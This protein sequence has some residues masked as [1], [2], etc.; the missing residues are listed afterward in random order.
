LEAGKIVTITPFPWDKNCFM[1]KELFFT[2][3]DSSNSPVYSDYGR[4]CADIPEKIGY[5]VNQSGT[6]YLKI[7]SKRNAPPTKYGLTIHQQTIGA[8]TI[9]S[10]ISGET[11]NAGQVV[12]IKWQA[13]TSL[14][15]I[16]IYCSFNNGATWKWIF[17]TDSSAGS[18]SWLAPPL[19]CTIS[20]TLIKVVANNIE[21]L[22]GISNGNLTIIQSPPDAYEPNYDF[23]LAYPI[24]IGDSVVKNAWIGEIDTSG[25]EGYIIGG[26]L[27]IDGMIDDYYKV[28][29]T[30]NK[31]TKISLSWVDGYSDAAPFI[32]LYDALKNEVQLSSDLTCTVA[33]SGTYYI[34]VSP[35]PNVY[36]KYHISI[37]QS[38]GAINLI[39]PRGGEN[40]S[41]AQEVKVRWTADTM[42]KQIDLYYSRDTGATWEKII[43]NVSNV[44]SDNQYCSWIVP[45]LKQRTDKALVRIQATVDNTIFA[46]SKS[47]F[48][49]Q[50][51]PLDAYEPN[52]D[53]ISAYPIAVG[54]SVVKN[55]TVCMIEE[56]KS[57]YDNMANYY[58][59]YSSYVEDYYKVSLSAGKITT[60]N[61]FPMELYSVSWYGRECL[62]FGLYK[63]S[64]NTVAY[65]ET[66]KQLKYYS[67]QSGIYYCK[68]MLM[69]DKRFLNYAKYGL[70]IRS[71]TVLSTQKSELD[72]TAYQKNT[73]V[74]GDPSQGVYRANVITDTTRLT[75]D[76]TTDYKSKLSL[77]TMVLSPD[78]LTLALNTKASIKAISILDNYNQI[79]KTADIT[80]PYALS[81]LNGNPEKMLMAFWLN[82]TTNQW[83]P[84][85]STI[86]TI[87]HQI[88][89]HDTRWGT[90]GVFVKSNTISS[91]SEPMPAPVNGITMNYQPHQKNVI[92]HLSLTK[93]AN[94]ELRLYNM[95]GKCV[96]CGYIAAGVGYSTF[97]W[98]FNA[99]ANGKYLLS[100]KAGMYHTK[101]PIVIMN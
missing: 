66:G 97:N 80:I 76:L 43:G 22:Y 9:I 52:D 56:M 62:N 4:E 15:D 91:L 58:K 36:G 25:T 3:Y 46:V 11:F 94:A 37:F 23:S 87:K 49:I 8:I 32:K 13:D 70:S 92:V 61:I 48:N 73:Q 77:T 51:V 82:D 14:H 99:L 42:I 24:T 17:A 16:G 54:D 71:L 64:N 38:S 57:K 26:D 50:A 34:V 84:V 31:F 21:N 53:C 59:D 65:A 93:S 69:S 89:V 60:I 79:I 81:G 39:S 67:T 68:V 85:T 1:I 18:Y 28:T 55:A 30:A 40:Y 83:I 27:L 2:L 98:H 75:I 72:T 90:Y 44:S 12:S 100:I 20:S 101:A 63:D 10:P 96:K 29:L 19:K 7:C 35:T 33:Q 5:Y 86:D 47:T 74:P 41:T 88:S 6:Y 45:P 78:E 95:Q